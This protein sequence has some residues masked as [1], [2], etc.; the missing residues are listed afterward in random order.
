VG[1]PGLQVT[2]QVSGSAAGGGQQVA[3]E[4]AGRAVAARRPP[5]QGER[6][7]ALSP[8]AE[9]VVKQRACCGLVDFDVV[10][11]PLTPRWRAS[12]LAQHNGARRL[13]LDS[14][15]TRCAR[16][17]LHAT[18]PGDHFT[19]T[20]V[21]R[22]SGPSASQKTAGSE[23]VAA[24]SLGSE[25]ATMRRLSGLSRTGPPFCAATAF[26]LAAL[27]PSRVERPVAS[28]VIF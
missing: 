3:E 18:S 23:Q 8:P 9:R 28:R 19:R 24:G 14:R 22:S 10:G 27:A 20:D 17:P 7:H 1:Y 6:G 25:L 4:P 15:L 21:I 16:A 26:M 13:K 5:F 11:Q 12:G 2:G